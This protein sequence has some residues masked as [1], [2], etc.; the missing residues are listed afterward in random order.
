MLSLAVGTVSRRNTT[1]M[2]TTM[3]VPLVAALLK[4]W[5]VDSV[6]LFSVF[7]DLHLAFKNFTTMAI[8]VRDIRMKGLNEY[9]N[10]STKLCVLYQSLSGKVQ[11]LLPLLL[12]NLVVVSTKSWLFHPAYNTPVINVAHLA[13]FTVQTLPVL[14]GKYIAKHFSSDIKTRMQEEYC[15]PKRNRK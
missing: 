11:T 13:V 6:I 5:L 3:A 10:E 12:L 2:E 1:E 4:A 14:R 15:F 9:K 8:L 7:L